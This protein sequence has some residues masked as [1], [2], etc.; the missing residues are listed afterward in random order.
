M[1]KPILFVLSILVLHAVSCASPEERND[2]LPPTRYVSMGTPVSELDDAIP[3]IYKDTRGHHWFGSGRGVVFHYDGHHLTRI[4]EKDGLLNAGVLAIQE[5]ADGHIYFDTQDGVQVFN[6]EQIRTLPLVEDDPAHPNEWA[7]NPGDLWFRGRWDQNGPYRWDG[8]SLYHLTF[9]D[10]P[11]LD[12]IAPSALNSSFSVYGIYSTYTDQDGRIW[13]GTS[14]LG[15]MVYDGRSLSYV[16][17]PGIIH[18]GDGPALGVRSIAQDREGHFLFST[19]RNRFSVP[20][21]LPAGLLIEGTDFEKMAGPEGFGRFHQD[22]FE[23]FMSAVT[24]PRT[25]DLWIATYDEGVWHYNG[26]ELT[27]YPVRNGDQEVNLFSIYMDRD[28]DLWVGTLQQGVYR[29]D[30][31][32]FYRFRGPG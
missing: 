11:A 28:G 15:A 22:R 20:T 25:G 26:R 13:F 14:N 21:D 9:P 31:E 16:A 12:T 3:L 29:F 5:D 18:L 6:G 32:S 23:E 2:S 4:T 24:D 8:D 27:H 19:I 1:P 10:H 30:G 17:D 7:L